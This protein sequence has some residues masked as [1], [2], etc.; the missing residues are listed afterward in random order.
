MIHKPVMLQGIVDFFQYL[1]EKDDFVFI[2]GTL[3]LAGHSLAIAK[4]SKSNKFKI[5]GIDLDEQALNL[6]K[7]KIQK[8]GFENNFILIHNNFKEVISFTDQQGIEKIDGALLDLGVSSLQLDELERGFSFKDPEQL[9]DMRMDQSARLS[10]DVVINSYEQKKIANLLFKWGEEKWGNQIARAIVEARKKEPIRK[11]GQLLKILER[12]IPKK[13]AGGKHFAT[14]TFQA[15]RIEVNKELVGLEKAISDFV[16]ILN[17]GGRIAII[18]FHSLEDRIVKNTFRELENPCVCPHD[19][20][21]CAC[22]KKPLVK[23]ISKKPIEATAE[24]VV[25]NPRAR[26]AKLRVAERL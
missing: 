26:S 16:E 24:E 22:G 15:L 11:V 9:L 17:P 4:L 18:A 2:D 8:K 21:V 12:A 14:K 10:A 7:E 1:K 20:P 13:K 23:I 19:L 3:G 25:Q 5:V 6:A